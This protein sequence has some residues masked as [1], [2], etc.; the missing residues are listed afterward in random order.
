MI[1]L[2][3][4]ALMRGNEESGSAE[5]I[6]ALRRRQ[7]VCRTGYTPTALFKISVDSIDPGAYY[8]L[9]ASGS[10]SGSA[11]PGEEVCSI[12]LMFSEPSAF[13]SEIFAGKNSAS[14]LA[15]AENAPRMED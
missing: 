10:W 14:L 7:M 11:F 8:E 3:E 4:M 5:R 13:K 9:Y 1:A 15:E 2:L 12:S 6:P